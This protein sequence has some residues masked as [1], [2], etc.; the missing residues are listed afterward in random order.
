MIFP[1]P[2]LMLGVV[3]VTAGLCA[4]S[5]KLGMEHQMATE[6]DKRE[7]V[8]EAVD[9]AANAAAATIA[10]LAPK[11][12]TIQGKLE[13]VIETNTVYTDCRLS[14]DGLLLANQALT[15]GAKLHGEGKLPGANTP[16]K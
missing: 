2:Y 8:A 7:L 1:N 12:T 4:G 11:Y 5:F 9:A 14:P 3:V 13:K 15:S 6:I 16:A 10:S